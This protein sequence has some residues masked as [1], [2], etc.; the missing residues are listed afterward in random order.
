MTEILK[1]SIVVNS[2]HIYVQ[3]FLNRFITFSVL[4]TFPIKRQL[5]LRN[6]SL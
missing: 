5:N 1:Q 3:I 6:L 4:K 2:M